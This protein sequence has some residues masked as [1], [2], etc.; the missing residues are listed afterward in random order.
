MMVAVPE[1]CTKRW[2]LEDGVHS[3]DQRERAVELCIKYGLKATVTVRELGYPSRAQLVSW[4]GEWQESGGRLTDRSLGQCTLEQKR[5][6]VRH[7]PAHGRCDALARRELG[8][9]K[10]TAKL[11]EWTDEYAP[12]E[13]GATQPRVFGASEKAAAVK[14]LASRASSAREVVDL[15]GCM[16]L[17]KPDF[18]LGGGTGNPYQAMRLGGLRVH[19]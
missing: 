8:Y 13:R 9:P 5:T 15:A 1:V 14:A 12:G 16:C 11:A 18:R 6:A 4:H 10:C 17:V 7:H 3:P 19:P 2:R